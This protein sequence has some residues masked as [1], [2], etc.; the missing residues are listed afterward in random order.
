MPTQYE[1]ARAFADAHD[2]PGI[3]VL[4][5]AWDVG[6][7]ILLVEAGFPF[8]A[9]TSAGVAFAQGLPDG[10]MD[11][12]EMLEIVGRIAAAVDV[13]VTADLEAGYGPTAEDVAL[14]IGG[15]LAAGAVGCNI[16]DKSGDRDHPLLDLDLAVERIRAGAGVI[17]TSGIPFVLNARTD[18][19]LA[20][21][22][23]PE[24]CFAEAVRRA[25]AY[26]EAGA[27]CLFVPGV[28][29][30]ETIGRLTREIDGPVNVLGAWGGADRALPVAEL[31]E[32][33][34]RRVSVG[35]SLTLAAFGVVRRAAAEL[36][37]R[38]TF[39]YARDAMS[40]A[41]ANRLMASRLSQP[42]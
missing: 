25:N 29:D 31:Q 7:A 15:A 22:G 32:L 33:G 6:T 18:P 5:N 16:E 40:G 4:P 26:R 24:E 14:T 12:S 1:K 23:T 17:R 39:G 20:R 21:I 3:V 10:G 41:E 38:G 36:R 34:V 30:A 42:R 13:P 8:I 27:G 11:R 35:G 37:E 9:T 2:G 28:G 19:F